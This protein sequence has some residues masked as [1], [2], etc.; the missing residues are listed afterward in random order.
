MADDVVKAAMKL[1]RGESGST[2][3]SKSQ[4]DSHPS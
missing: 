1:V 4:A 2:E 3:K